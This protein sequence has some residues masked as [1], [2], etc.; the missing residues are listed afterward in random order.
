MAQERSLFL[1]RAFFA[2][3]TCIYYELCAPFIYVR[4]VMGREKAKTR[5]ITLETKAQAFFEGIGGWSFDFSWQFRR[6]KT[7]L[8]FLRKISCKPD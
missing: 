8:W 4:R 6:V 5:A 3:V 2:H 1:A 7:E